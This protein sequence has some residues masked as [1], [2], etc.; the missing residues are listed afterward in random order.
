MT[1]HKA[2][3]VAAALAW[4]LRSAF[5]RIYELE[6]ENNYGLAHTAMRE[7]ISNTLRIVDMLRNEH[8]FLP[9]DWSSIS[10]FCAEQKNTHGWFGWI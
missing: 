4:Q 2:I 8:P 3:N 6:S 10:K 9:H 5:T 1:R 7:Q